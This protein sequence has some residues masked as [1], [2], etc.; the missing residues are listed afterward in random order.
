MIIGG[1]LRD[2][3][4]EVAAV[5]RRLPSHLVCVQGGCMPLILSARLILR[6]RIHTSMEPKDA[7]HNCPGFPTE[8][9]AAVDGTLTLLW[10]RQASPVHMHSIALMLK[11]I[12]SFSYS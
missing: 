11:P 5:H 12:I 4:W 6:H 10:W 8:A 7:A 3:K 9:N 2:H 1:R